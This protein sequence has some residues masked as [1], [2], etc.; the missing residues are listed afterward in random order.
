MNDNPNRAESQ[1][2]RALIVR[3]LEQGNTLTSLQALNRFGCARMA[4]RIDELRR[5]GLNIVTTMIPVKNRDGK[6][7]R[8]AE[9][10]LAEGKG[11]AA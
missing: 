6:Q 3:H 9:Y 11:V 2:Q 5:A 8:V 1:T 4:S 7:V 10:R